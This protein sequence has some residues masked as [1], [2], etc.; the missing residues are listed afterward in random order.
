[1]YTQILNLVDIKGLLN[2]RYRFRSEYFA[3]LYTF[4]SFKYEIKILF[5]NSYLNIL[6]QNEMQIMET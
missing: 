2:T 4:V 6:Q 5:L 1:M 3:L